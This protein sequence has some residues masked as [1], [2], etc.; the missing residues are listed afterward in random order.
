M[1]V[2]VSKELHEGQAHF[3]NLTPPWPRI[4]KLGCCKKFLPPTFRLRSANKLTTLRP[5]RFIVAGIRDG[6]RGRARHRGLWITR[7][8]I[9][10]SI[11]HGIMAFIKSKGSLTQHA[12]T[13]LLIPILRSMII[14]FRN[15]AII[16]LMIFTLIP[17]LRLFPRPFTIFPRRFSIFTRIFCFN[18]PCI[19]LM[20]F[21]RFSR[22]F[23]RSSLPRCDSN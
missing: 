5:L 13:S 14:N 8:L 4:A 10:I 12:I 11:I 19:L 7:V 20:R 18:F 21:N 22:F 16:T 6:A 2:V 17:R 3:H 1:W 9:L 15:L 23:K